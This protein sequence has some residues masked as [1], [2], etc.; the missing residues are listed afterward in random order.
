V[1][2]HNLV[3]SNVPGLREKRYINGA[4]IEAEYPM[5]LLVPGQAMNIT[6]ISHADQL[7]V[8]VLV[9]PSLVPQPQFVT[10]AIAAELDALGSA[11][12][13]RRAPAARHSAPAAPRASRGAARQIADRPAHATHHATHHAADLAADLVAKAAAR[14]LPSKQAAARKAAGKAAARTPRSRT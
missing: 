6:V 10:D 3:L 7:H 12:R 5:S 14:Q 1:H 13:G 4:L 11:R 9:C 2:V 8:A